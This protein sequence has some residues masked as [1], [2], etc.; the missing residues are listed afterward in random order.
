MKRLVLAVLIIVCTCGAVV[1]QEAQ[2]LRVTQKY[3]LRRSIDGVYQGLVYGYQMGSW[4]FSSSDKPHQT[5]V[6][7]DYET[8]WES[9]RDNA[10]TEKQL[11]ST[12]SVRFLM[13]DKGIMSN[14]EGKG[15]PTYRN[16]ISP[17]PLSKDKTVWTVNGS[18]VG[19]FLDDQT[20]T[21]VPVLAE[22]ARTGEGTF[23][24]QKVLQARYRFALR[25]HKGDDVGGDPQLSSLLGSHSGTVSYDPQT[26]R[27]VFISEQ[28]HRE[29]KSLQGKMIVE[30]GFVLTFF[31]GVAALPTDDLAAQWKQKLVT[32][33]N[34]NAGP[35]QPKAEETQPSVGVEADPRGL[36]L[37]LKNL[38]FV[39][40]QATLLPGQDPVLKSMITL[41]RTVPERQILVIGHTAAVGSVESQDALSIDRAKAIVEELKKGGV[42]AS[43]ILFEGR[44]GKDPVAPNDTEEGRSQNRRVEVIV[45]NQ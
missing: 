22:F 44:G 37:T 13:D 19:D 45:L 3:D 28:I 24:G 23:A 8:A 31:E 16:L 26:G 20:L 2:T 9:R 1:A 38:Q 25:Y 12:T 29:A 14:F 17:L 15:P 43:H 41:L 30:E 40:N 21:E 4:K 42:P 10:L 32:L 5:A 18:V 39:A 6:E 34:L 27:P 11:A 36:K 7:A 35:S 33:D